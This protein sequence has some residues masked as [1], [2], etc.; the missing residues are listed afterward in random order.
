MGFGEVRIE[1]QRFERCA[2]DLVGVISDTRI[3]PESLQQ[4]RLGEPRPCHGETGVGR[5]RLGVVIDRPPER[6]GIELLDVELSAQVQLVGPR[7]DGRRAPHVA[8]VTGGG[9]RAEDLHHDGVGSLRLKVEDALDGPL[10]RLRPDLLLSVGASQAE[11]DAHTFAGPLD[12]ALDDPI[13]PEL[14]TDGGKR[15]AAA[16]PVALRGREGDDLE[17]LDGGELR[18]E[19]RRHAVAEVRLSG[20]TRDTDERE[21]RNTDGR[22]TLGSRND[23]TARVAPR[24]QGIRPRVT[25]RNT[26]T[27]I[28][29]TAAAAA[30]RRVLRARARTSSSLATATD[31]AL[32]SGSEGPLSGSVPS[33]STWSSTAVSGTVSR[34]VRAA[35]HASSS[36]VKA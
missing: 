30:R 29:A 10:E 24:L 26:A 5:N 19:R 7:I 27:D 13:D 6:H 31:A 35:H 12:G 33:S 16:L 34:A 18:G 23:T 25:A 20:A 32:G 4:I 22:S 1:R 21:Y 15:L 36:S 2:P 28:K 9:V 3:P 8:R 14:V 17:G 11:G